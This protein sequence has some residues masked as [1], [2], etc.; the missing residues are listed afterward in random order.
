[1]SYNNNSFFSSFLSSAAAIANAA[2][3]FIQELV[4]ETE[5]PLGTLTER[6]MLWDGSGIPKI[7]DVY[8][9]EYYRPS[10]THIEIIINNTNEFRDSSKDKHKPIHKKVSS[11]YDLDRKV[12]TLGSKYVEKGYVPVFCNWVN[13]GREYKVHL[14]RYDG[15][16]VTLWFHPTW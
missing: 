15:K 5:T 16:T 11:L 3:P 2:A 12:R 4:R 7:Y 9:N 1:M 14:K 13:K 10:N 8:S 6:K